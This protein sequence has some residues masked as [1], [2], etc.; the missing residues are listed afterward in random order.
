MHVHV[1]RGHQMPD[2]MSVA[3]F[4]Q[5]TVHATTFVDDSSI[6]FE[7]DC[8]MPKHLAGFDMAASTDTYKQ[9]VHQTDAQT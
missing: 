7:Q 6:A 2:F 9:A 5:N 1:G 4:E 3:L 8:V